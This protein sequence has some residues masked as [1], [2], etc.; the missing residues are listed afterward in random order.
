[1]SHAPT[2][3]DA[4]LLTKETLTLNITVPRRTPTGLYNI[5]ITAKSEGGK[6]V[7]RQMAIYAEE[8]L[9]VAVTVEP[10]QRSGGP[11]KEITFRMNLTN[12]GNGPQVMNP[13]VLNPQTFDFDMDKDI[14]LGPFEGRSMELTARIPSRSALT[15]YNFT[16]GVSALSDPE[17]TWNLTYFLIMVTSADLV[18]GEAAL[19]VSKVTPGSV[20]SVRTTVQNIG[21]APAE[22]V[23]VGIYEPGSA[24]P[25]AIQHFD[26]VS[27]EQEVYL[28][29][30]VKGSNTDFIIKADPNNTVEEINEMNND[31]EFSYKKEYRSESG[32]T[33]TQVFWIACLIGAGLLLAL[34][35]YAVFLRRKEF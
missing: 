3:L 25:L 13:Q 15:T 21:N 1:M 10:R 29:W 24:I 35:G 2:T 20:V 6:L 14:D 4:R 33:T 18:V 32:W 27:G 11:G 5:T 17:N 9:G 16:L 30:I 19:D 7:P 8:Y 26:V 31:R 34:T 28:Q 22:N 12:L 23:T